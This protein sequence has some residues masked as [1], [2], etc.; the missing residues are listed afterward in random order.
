VA[1]PARAQQ[2][3]MRVIG[4]LHAGSERTQAAAVAGSVPNEV[5][6]LAVFLA[7]GLK[8]QAMSALCPQFGLA[9]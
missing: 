6:G 5:F 8:L 2:Q 7:C 3:A 1:A 9:P 4:F